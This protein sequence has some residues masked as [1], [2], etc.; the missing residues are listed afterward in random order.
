MPY[1]DARERHIYLN[2]RLQELK[3]F[4]DSVVKRPMLCNSEVVFTF[5][6]ENWEE[7]KKN[8]RS[9]DIKID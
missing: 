1:L 6:L 5:F 9:I 4:I 8:K 7:F 3:S 2:S